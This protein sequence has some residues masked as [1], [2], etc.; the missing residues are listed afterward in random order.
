MHVQDVVNVVEHE[1][2]RDIVLVG[3]SYGG[4]VITMVADRIADRLRRVVYL[5]AAAPAHGQAS[6]GAFAEGTSDKLAEMSDAEWLLPPLPLAAVGVTDEADGKWMDARRHPHP[7]P[8]LQAP[9]E[10]SGASNHVPRS[11]IVHTH[12]QVLIELF[13]VDPLSPFV[14]R[15]KAEGWRMQEIAAG[16]DAMFTHPRE[17]ADALLAELA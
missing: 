2:L 5:D 3:H 4:A 10:L 8:T 15:A 9:L 11:Y 16:H 17:V 14:A 7:M 12:K 13:G 1:D 6:T